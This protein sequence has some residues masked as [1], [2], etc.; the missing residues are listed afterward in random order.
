MENKFLFIFDPLA[1]AKIKREV[2]KLKSVES[3]RDWKEYYYG[4]WEQSQEQ[5]FRRRQRIEELEMQE[6]MRREYESNDYRR[7]WQSGNPFSRAITA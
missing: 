7:I 1:Y 3:K 5:M 6:R 4:N 2:S